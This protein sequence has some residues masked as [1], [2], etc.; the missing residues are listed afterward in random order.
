MKRYYTP[1]CISIFTMLSGARAQRECGICPCLN[2]KHLL[3]VFSCV[4]SHTFL[5]YARQCWHRFSE[6]NDR[7]S[8]Q[9]NHGGGMLLCTDTRG[10]AATRVAMGT[11]RSAD[12]GHPRVSLVGKCTLW[13]GDA[14]SLDAASIGGSRA[15]GRTASK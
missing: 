9:P 6:P 7:P 13:M 15:D 12:A 2:L 5:R 8:A 1:I 10:A 4:S 11:G 3:A 14:V